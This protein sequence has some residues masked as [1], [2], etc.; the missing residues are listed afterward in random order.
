M[1]M[2]THALC[3]LALH[4]SLK[5][6]TSVMRVCGKHMPHSLCAADSVEDEAAT[7]AMHG[8]LLQ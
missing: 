2:L 5:G 1:Y 3:M 4:A 6:E 7:F 8:A